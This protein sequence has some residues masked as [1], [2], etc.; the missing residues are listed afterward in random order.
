MGRWLCFPECK[1]HPGQKAEIDSIVGKT[2]TAM[3]LTHI[4]GQ[5]MAWVVVA[6][7][8]IYPT[9]RIF[10]RAGLNPVLSLFLYIPYMGLFIVSGIL[11]LA[12]WPA[13]D[14]KNAGGDR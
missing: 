2:G 3:N 4:L 14:R 8:L 11:A 12:E 9:W 10:R 7:L 5:V 6:S 13:V 1:A